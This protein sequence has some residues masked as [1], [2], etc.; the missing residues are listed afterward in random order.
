MPSDISGMTLEN[1]Q[2]LCLKTDGCLSINYG[3][4]RIQLSYVT[5]LDASTDWISDPG[6]ESYDIYYARRGGFVDNMLWTLSQ[7]KYRLKRYRESHHMDKMAV[8]PSYI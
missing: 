3:S 5:R 2:N 1:S 6:G 7:L 8:G 4:S